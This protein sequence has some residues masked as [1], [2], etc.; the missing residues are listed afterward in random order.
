MLWTGSDD[1]LVHLSRDGGESWRN[2]T[3]PDLPEWAFIRT[4]EPSPHDPA[5]LYLAAT[6]YKLDDP[7]PYLYRTDDYGES[8]RTIIG[9]GGD[10]AI[11]PDDFV[12]VVRADPGCPG[13]L[14][15]GT[16]TGLYISLDDGANWRRWRSNFPVTPVYDLKIEGSDLVIATHGRSFWIMDDLTPL[17]REARATAE[18][19]GD[20]GAGEAS[21]SGCRAG[22][23]G[24]YAP[25]RAWRLLPG[26]MD[27]I[28]GADGK[29]YSIG[30]GKPATFIA[31][32]DATGQVRRRF[33]DAGEAAPV[34]A[35]VYYRLPGNF[36]ANEQ[37]HAKSAPDVSIAIHDSTGALV[38]EFHP[39]PAGY[40]DLSDEDKALE[41]GPWAPVQAGVN[42]FVWDLRY[43]ERCGCEATRPGRKPTGD[44]W[45][46]RAPIGYASAL[47]TAHS[48]S[49]SRW[50]TTPDR[51]RVSTSSGNSS[52]ASSRCATR[53]PPPTK[54]CSA[55]GM[56]AARSSGGAHA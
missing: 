2:V 8:W 56:R 41:P 55:S 34:G 46:C 22:Q 30:L 7:A 38:R 26:V 13:V 43:R 10:R 50:S 47:V 37:G 20:D 40:D 39:K 4:V 1:G 12:R 29:D 11:P 16:E 42:R 21:D 48:P 49:G 17:H 35:I 31:K 44:P 6:R 36:A 25:R 32:R 15:A 19:D 24:L 23:P 54:A 5:T 28:T 53:S 27:F 14:Y 9:S 51:R 45:C 52:T 18:R 33:L 3:P